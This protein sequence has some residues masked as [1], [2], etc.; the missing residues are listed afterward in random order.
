[1][2]N[3]RRNLFDTVRN[4]LSTLCELFR[5]ADDFNLLAEIV[6]K[7]LLFCFLFASYPPKK[8]KSSF[9]YTRLWSTKSNGSL[10][11]TTKMSHTSC[12]SSADSGIFWIFYKRIFFKIPLM[13]YYCL[14]PSLKTKLYNLIAT[15]C[16]LPLL[17]LL[18]LTFPLK[19]FT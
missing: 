8:H 18:N 15:W 1:M 9:Q 17:L 7:R 3:T 11:A 6:R 4:A 19:D 14:V 5:W 10:E 16:A 2:R 13:R 12:G